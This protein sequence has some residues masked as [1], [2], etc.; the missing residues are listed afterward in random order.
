MLVERVNSRCSRL[1]SGLGLVLT[2]APGSMAAEGSIPDARSLGEGGDDPPRVPFLSMETPPKV[3]RPA[4][5][6]HVEGGPWRMG[7]H[8]G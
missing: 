7:R 1:P 2:P 6:S 5:A 4:R 8:R 3:P